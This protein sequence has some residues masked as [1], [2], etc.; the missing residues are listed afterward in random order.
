VIQVYKDMCDFL[1]THAHVATDTKQILLD[2]NSP[3]RLLALAMYALN[4][5][6]V[7][8]TSS[9][10]TS[11]HVGTRYVACRLC[12]RSN[13]LPAELQYHQ[14]FKCD[15]RECMQC[16]NAIMHRSLLDIHVRLYCGETLITCGACNHPRILRKNLKHHVLHECKYL[17]YDSNPRHQLPHVLAASAPTPTTAA[18]TT[19]DH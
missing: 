17:G 15:V 5:D 2:R 3:D 6:T 1:L 10:G 11:G 4:Q 18:P 14:Q 9:S 13:L 19:A 8:K 12:K 7:D 16:K